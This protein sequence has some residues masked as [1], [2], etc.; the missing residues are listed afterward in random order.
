[1]VLSCGLFGYR[2]EVLAA[3]LA[4]RTGRWLFGGANGASAR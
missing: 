3:E 1:M 4:R 2:P